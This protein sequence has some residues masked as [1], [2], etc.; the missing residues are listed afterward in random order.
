MGGAESAAVYKSL[1]SARTVLD[2][3]MS[4]LRTKE[5]QAKYDVFKAAGGLGGGCRL[6]D[7][8]PLKTYTYWKIIENKYPYGL[9]AKTHH[10]AVPIRHTDESGMTQDEWY[11][12]G[13]LKHTDI[14]AQY[15]YLMEAT[16]KVKTIPSHFHIHLIVTKD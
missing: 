3:Y 6:C 9:F 7:G 8:E 15:E 12:W 11:E 5:V 13:T 14:D 10:M 4:S 2:T 16:R 1:N